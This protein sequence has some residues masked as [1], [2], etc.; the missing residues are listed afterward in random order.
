LVSFALGGGWGADYPVAGTVPVAVIRGTDFGQVS[1]GWMDDVPRRWE[2]EK[3]LARRSLRP[4]DLVLEIS[5][6]SSA[7]GQSTGR[8]LLITPEILAALRLPVMPASFCRLVRVDTSRVLAKY[9]SYALRDMHVS[10][11]AASYE[12][13]ST[14]ISNF[15]FE[16]FLDSEHVRVPSLEEQRAVVAVLQALDD[17]IA[18]TDK[19]GSTALELAR[20]IAAEALTGAPRERLDSV[21]RITMGSAPPGGTYNEGGVGLPFYQGCRD[22]GRS[23]PSVRVWCSEPVRTADAGSILLSVRAPVGRA[24][25]TLDDCC[26]GRGVAAISSSCGNNSLLRYALDL[27]SD[28][29]EKYES[30]GTVFGSIGKDQLAAVAVPVLA[31]DAS[32]AVEGRLA[33]LDARVAAGFLER[34]AL[35]RLRDLLL[36]RLM[37]GE[38]RVRDAERTV[39]EVT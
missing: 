27:R 35:V 28:E 18:I 8:S 26:I 4:G 10:G 37:S 34:A 5:G 25:V 15:Q 20:C 7:R 6:G 31:G 17:R 1:A 30:N 36:P 22:F 24:N 13:Q 39:E 21:A 38:I 16:S 29:W 12:N 2:T 14:G 19:I 33:E 32:K 11:R 3:R 23:F 9:A